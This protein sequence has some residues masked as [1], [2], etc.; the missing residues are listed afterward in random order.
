MKIEKRR[1]SKT[2]Y[3]HFQ[4]TVMPFGLTNAPAMFMDLMHRVMRE[5]LDRF[6]IVFIDDILIYSRTR[7]EHEGHLRTVLQTLRD[8]RLFAKFSKCEFWL[9]EVRFLG[10]VV[11]ATGVA[12]DPEKVRAVIEWP[13]PTTV[14]QIRS[15]LGLAGYYRRFVQDFSKIAAPMTK[16]TKKNA[17][18]DWDE[19]CEHAFNTLK[20]KLTTAPV[21]ALPRGWERLSGVHR[22][23][24]GWL[25][26]CI[27]ARGQSYRLCISTI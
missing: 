25:G 20:Q 1:R 3:G 16:L 14:T 23:V 13:T 22:R 9:S 10:H 24:E 26:L 5:Y 17:K 4:F 15:F 11:G 6:V 7:E 2:R 12:V 8:H 27:D 21:L 19:E 18:F